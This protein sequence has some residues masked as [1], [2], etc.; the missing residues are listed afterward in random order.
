MKFRRRAIL[1]RRGRKMTRK[2]LTLSVAALALCVCASA[3]IIPSLDSGNP[4]DLMNGTF[5]FNYTLS[6]SNLERL[7]PV[8]TSSTTCPP[9]GSTQCNPPGTFSPIYD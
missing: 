5:A 8:A 3:D 2:L 6:L 7:D 9:T 1:H 4:V